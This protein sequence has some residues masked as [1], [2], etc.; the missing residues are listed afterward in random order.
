LVD[1]Q[2]LSHSFSGRASPPFSLTNYQ[3]QQKTAKAKTKF[4]KLGALAVADD[5]RRMVHGLDGS[6]T[7]MSSLPS[8]FTVRICN[9]KNC[10]FVAA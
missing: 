8:P 2:F 10:Q 3:Q 9:L 7:V 6:P 1:I 4:S 5:H